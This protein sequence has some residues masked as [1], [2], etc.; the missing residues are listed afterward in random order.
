LFAIEKGDLRVVKFMMECW[1]KQ[2]LLN[3]RLEDGR[4]ALLLAIESRTLPLIEYLLEH[5]V[6][7]VNSY[8]G[9][10]PTMCA[11]KEKLPELAKKFILKGHDIFALDSDGNDIFV[12]TIE[13]KDF[14]LVI[15]LIENGFSPN[16][17][18]SG[19]W[20]PLDIA[21]F[22]PR[23]DEIMMTILQFGGSFIKSRNFAPNLKIQGFNDLEKLFSS[24][25]FGIQDR[26]SNFSDFPPI[27][28][29]EKLTL[30]VV[31]NRLDLLKS[32]I[33]ETNFT[34]LNDKGN[35]ILAQSIESYQM[36]IFDFIV[37]NLNWKEL[38]VKNHEGFL[39]IHMALQRGNYHVIRTFCQLSEPSVKLDHLCFE[40]T[41][42]HKSLFDFLKQW[43]I[44]KS[45]KSFDISFQF[46]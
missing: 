37:K 43:R 10:T 20:S 12:Y 39:P 18:Y 16:R 30:C 31:H 19:D 40:K 14:N 23:N 13:N 38:N 6:P 29:A 27:S 24:T 17:I 15:Y 26:L 42:I 36:E 45:T 34:T 1:D 2:I 5:N 33:D 9:L 21:I 8:D 11:I 3:Q 25:I 35:N 28:F 4:N 32:L 41:R 22:C 46:Q 7:E 44:L